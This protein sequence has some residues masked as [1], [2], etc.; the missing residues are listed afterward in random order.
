MTMAALIAGHPRSRAPTLLFFLQYIHN[1]LARIVPPP[2]LCL[3]ALSRVV[4]Q[5][6]AGSAHAV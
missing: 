5:S 2:T 4:R 3:C 6:G 1:A